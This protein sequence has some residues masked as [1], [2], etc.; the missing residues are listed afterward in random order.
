MRPLGAKLAI[1]GVGI[2]DETVEEIFN[3][4]KPNV[5]KLDMNEI[6]TL[7]DQEEF[8][9]MSKIKEYAEEHDI[10]LIV[11]NMESPA[12]LSHVFPYELQLVQGDGLVPAM[13]G[14]E[15]D[16]SEPLF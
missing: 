7:E 1:S 3:R 12:Q 6:D 2:Y 15:F 16:F 10:E 8:Q 9:F 11:A 5:L 13:D 4:V 14:F